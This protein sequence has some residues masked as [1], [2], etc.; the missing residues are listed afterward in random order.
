MAH[1]TIAIAMPEILILPL[2]EATWQ[3]M[4]A[5]CTKMRHR[6][7]LKRR[8]TLCFNV[9]LLTYILPMEISVAVSAE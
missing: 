1:I 2:D 4:R 8:F 6:A 9:K 7:Q 5:L 3:I